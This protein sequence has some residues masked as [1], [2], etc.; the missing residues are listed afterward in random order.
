MPTLGTEIAVIN[1]GK[2]LLTLRSDIPMWCLPGGIVEPGETVAQAAVREVREETGLDVILTHLVGIYSRPN[3]GQGGDHG[4]I[5]AAQPVG[6]TLRP[7]DGEAVAVDYFDPAN[8]PEPLFGWHY[9]RIKDA[10][11]GKTGQVWLQDCILPFDLSG[12]TRPEIYAQLDKGLVSMDKVVE[13]LSKREI[14][15][16]QRLEV[17]SL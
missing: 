10:L 12:K 17:G 4:V 7:A 8:L 15:T 13:Q 3:W 11:S 5:F 14:M 1:E 6:G 9:Q 2:I 16:L